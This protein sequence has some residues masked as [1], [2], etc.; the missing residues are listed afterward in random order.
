MVLTVKPSRSFSDELLDQYRQQGDIPADTVITSIVE[1]EGPTG[2][3]TLMRWL[4]DVDNVTTIDQPLA[5]QRFFEQYAHLPDWADQSRMKRSMDVFQKHDR[6]IGLLL[7]CYSLPYCYLGAQG[8]QV[9]WL[10]ERIKHDTKRR[11]QETSEW[12]Y[13]VNNPK[14]WAT[15]KAI[16]RTLK[17]RLIHAGVRWYTLRSNRWDMAWGHPV[18]QEDMAGTNGAFS[19]I[20]LR[21]LRKSGITL[22]EQQEEDY[23]HHS[24][25]IGFLNGVA[26]ELLPQNLREAYHL[27]RAISRRH[28]TTSEAG[29]GLTSSL[30]NAIAAGIPDLSS[31]QRPETLR[32]LAAGEMRFFLG[33]TYADWLGIPNAPVE[34]RI[35]GLLNRFPIFPL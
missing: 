8:A 13:A 35:A 24:N 3:H 22:S 33:D 25:V 21:G 28:F 19:Y 31:N 30:L 18:N 6:L 20:V 23:L 2:L 14:E 5:V 32:N 9:L 11:L 29:I 17:V 26:T 15:G 7:G 12:V 16:I 10:T 34:K 27:D 4:A 1:A